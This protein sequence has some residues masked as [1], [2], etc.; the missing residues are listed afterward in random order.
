[1]G[2]KATIA[3]MLIALEV[4]TLLNK[5]SVV[6]I[7]ALVVTFAYRVKEVDVLVDTLANM[8]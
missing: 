2:A 5:L 7:K 6:K 3:E 1:V 4:D 8:L